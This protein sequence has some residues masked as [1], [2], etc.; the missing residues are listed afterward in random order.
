MRI[1]SSEFGNFSCERR[2]VA[3][4]TAMELKAAIDDRIDNM[5]RLNDTSSDLD[6]RVPDRVRVAKQSLTPNR[7]FASRASGVLHLNPQNNDP[8]SLKLKDLGCTE[9]VAHRYTFNTDDKS[10][11]YKHSRFGVG[12]EVRIDK[13][14]GDME[15]SHSFLGLK[16]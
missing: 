11:V 10:T 16:F 9:M 1:P 8:T 2:A 13:A 7:L 5:L 14:S 15:I 6:N 3:H 4:R 12:Y